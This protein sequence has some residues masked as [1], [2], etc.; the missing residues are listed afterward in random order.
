M[1]LCIER[2]HEDGRLANFKAPPVYK[3]RTL[4]EGRKLLGAACLEFGRAV[5]RDADQFPWSNPDI[6][7]LFIEVSH[8]VD[9][10]VHVSAEKPGEAKCF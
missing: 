8:A 7:K 3:R 1:N 4:N 9:P 2:H 6:R 5:E 10:R